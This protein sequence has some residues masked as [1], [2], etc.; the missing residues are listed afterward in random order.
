MVE[1]R[2]LRRGGDGTCCE[3]ANS[4]R[5]VDRWR[6]PAPYGAH[7]EVDAVTPCPLVTPLR[8]EPISWNH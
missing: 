3:R 7:L 4:G 6:S 2:T 1:C 5:K 8:T